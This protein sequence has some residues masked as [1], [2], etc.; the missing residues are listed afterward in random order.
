MN[1][2]IATGRFTADPE[3]RKTPGGASV[4]SFTLAVGKDYPDKDGNYGTDFINCVAWN[5]LADS[6][7]QKRKK[8]DLVEIRGELNSHTY[9]DKETKKKRTRH[10]V[11]VERIRKL[12][13]SSGSAK[14][15][16][17][18][19]FAPVNDDAGD[20]PFED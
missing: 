7:G 20:L 12:S 19:D 9:E 18:S 11:K 3:L 14:P 10:D 2:F 15:E 8:G 1:V 4:V 5:K 13:Y 16:E 6:I 17:P